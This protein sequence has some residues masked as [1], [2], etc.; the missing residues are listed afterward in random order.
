MDRPNYF[1]AHIVNLHASFKSKAIKALWF[2]LKKQEQRASLS[3]KQQTTLQANVWK[4]AK[5]NQRRRK[6][7]NQPTRRTAAG[8]GFGW[9]WDC[10]SRQSNSWSSC[11]ATIFAPSHLLPTMTLQNTTDTAETAD[12]WDDDS[13]HARP[14]LLCGVGSAKRLFMVVSFSWWIIKCTV[15]GDSGWFACEQRAVGSKMGCKTHTH[16]NTH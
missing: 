3:A 15:P 12:G 11:G 10:R 4:R 5:L 7:V 1:N 9:A 13:P 8:G 14:L 2:T 6:R 16:T